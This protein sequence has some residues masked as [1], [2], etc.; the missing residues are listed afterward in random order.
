MSFA[1]K[2]RDF[3]KILLKG[4]LLLVPTFGFY[5]FWLI[6]QVRRHLWANTRVGSE[7]FE[8]TG[9]AKEILIGFLIA[10]AILVPIYAAYTILGLLAEEVRAFASIPLVLVLYV[11]GSF[12]SY[13]ARRYRATRTIFRG[14][15]FWMTGSGWAYAGR[16]AI[17]D[18]LT[19]VT[20]GFA[21]PWRTAALERYK[22][23]HTRYGDLPGDFV[24]AGG[25]LLRRAWWIWALGWAI[26]VTVGAVLVTGGP[27]QGPRLFVLLLLL[28]LPLLVP[29]FL[30]IQARWQA[31]GTRFGEV[32]IVSDLRTGA[33]V[34]TFLKLFFCLVGLVV[35]FVA[36][37]IAMIFLFR[38]QFEAFGVT[39]FTP[40]LVGVSAL[41]AVLYLALLLGFGLLQRYFMTRGLWTVLVGS[42]SLTNVAALDRVVA[43]G[44]VASGLGEGFADA[45]DL[46]GV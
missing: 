13:R 24:G 4:T 20:L 6:T 1:G 3:I 37:A 9:T 28:V 8:Y 15:R 43:A 33:F 36:A 7:A 35:A 40:T 16:A 22:M 34:G 10:L 17:W 2:S 29:L 11:F 42:L 19:V 23:R 27:Q 39:G 12:A 46:G 31:E 45:F 32:R 30:S 38:S 21:Y 44:E 14:I 25:I 18:L 26:W 5:R 41:G